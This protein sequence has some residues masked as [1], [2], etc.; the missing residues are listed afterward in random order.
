VLR[1]ILSFAIALHFAVLVVNNL[2]WSP[3]VARLFPLYSWYPI[4]TGQNQNWSMYQY[5]I[6]FQPDFHLVARFPDGAE[7]R[8]WGTSRRMRAREVYLLEKLFLMNDGNRLAYRLFDALHDRY[9]ADYRPTEI[10]LRRTTSDTPPMP[11]QIDHRP[12]S[13]ARELEISKRW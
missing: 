10:V 11:G 7:T 4:A 9:P 2:P 12:A 13:V 5:P 1:R 3:F 8:P 6:H